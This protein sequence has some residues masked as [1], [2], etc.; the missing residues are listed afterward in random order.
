MQTYALKLYNFFRFGEKDNTIVFDISK[1][2]KELLKSGSISMDSIYESF[3]EDPIGHIEASKTRG[4]ESQIGI[5][6]LVDGNMDFSNGVGKS[7]I[8]DALCYSRYEKIVRKTANTDKKEK[9]GLS[10]VT[11]INGEYPEDLRESYVEEFF[12][13]N[14]CIYRVKRGRTFSKT[15][16]SSSPILEF[17]RVYK[18]DVDRQESHRTGDTNKSIE[19]V[20]SIDYDLFVNSLMFGQNDAGK[21]LTGTD[22]IKKEMLIKLLSLEDMIVNCLDEIRL[23][24][25]SQDKQVQKLKSNLE[26]VK[27]EVVNLSSKYKKE[28]VL[29]EE[30]IFNQFETFIANAIEK[31]NLKYKD[32]E[33]EKAKIVEDIYKIES[34]DK[35]IT[36]EKIKKEGLDLK[37]SKDKLVADYTAQIEDWTQMSKDLNIQLSS[38][39]SFIAERKSSIDNLNL[40]IKSLIDKKNKFNREDSAQLLTKYCLALDKEASFLS[41][42]SE[43]E[44]LI[45]NLNNDIVSLTSEFNRLNSELGELSPQIKQIGDDEKYI[46]SHCK[47]VVSKEHIESEIKFIQLNMDKLKETKSLKKDEQDKLDENLSTIK[48]KLEKISEIKL[49]KV[50]LESEIKMQDEIDNNIHNIEDSVLSNTSEITKSNEDIAS[51]IDKI[52]KTKI[53]IENIKNDMSNQVSDLDL[54]INNL[55]DAYAKADENAKVLRDKIQIRKLQIKERE[56]IQAQIKEKIGGLQ[57]DISRINELKDSFTKLS[58]EYIVENKIFNRYLILE[59]VYSLDGIQTKIISKYLPLFNTHIE[60]YLDILSD[61]KIKVEIVINDGSKIDMLISGSTGQSYDM[62]SG[63]EKMIVK[64]AVNIGMALLSFIRSSKKPEIICLDEIFG[65]LDAD[66][67]DKTLKMLN[68]IKDTFNRALII[69]HEKDICDYL[70]SKLIIEKSGGDYGR[71]KILRIE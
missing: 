30:K 15:Q 63:G 55:R 32:L 29:F 25:N 24:K 22:K 17:E 41:S 50:Q 43:L 3:C 65:C 46:C 58:E 14:G 57:S 51:L 2:Q 23:K 36:V 39:N 5:I 8:L 6:G 54:K 59:S 18:D 1:E 12:E 40:K 52:S 71:S 13:E 9:A 42:K 45:L 28:E 61:G 67:R 38:K 49:K 21:F 48:N 47:S 70:G 7:S 53:K 16:K 35:I 20:L 11:N 4:L 62:L 33:T 68:K 56:D 27:S 69:S 44:K 19:E 66:H 64:L 37:T 10:V 31:G 34:D 60:E 26:F